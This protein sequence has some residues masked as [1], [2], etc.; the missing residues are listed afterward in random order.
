MGDKVDLDEVDRA[1]IRSLQE[2][3]RMGMQTL[4]TCIRS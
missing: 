4:K 2:N 3:A 1:I